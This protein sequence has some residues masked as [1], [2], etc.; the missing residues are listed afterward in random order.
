MA[1]LSA[2]FVFDPGEK[3]ESGCW[4]WGWGGGGGGVG[5]WAEGQAGDRPM[6]GRQWLSL[7]ASSV[8]CHINR[9]SPKAG[10]L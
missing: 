8:P 2:P 6:Y 3:H 4:G 1:M 10:N 7:E 5:G 9:L